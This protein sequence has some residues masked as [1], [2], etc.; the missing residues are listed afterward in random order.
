MVWK[1]GFSIYLFVVLPQQVSQVWQCACRG[2]VWTHAPS[3]LA[4]SPP[5]PPDSWSGTCLQFLYRGCLDHIDKFST[6][7]DCLQQ[8]SPQSVC[9]V[10]GVVCVCVNDPFPLRSSHPHLPYTRTH[11]VCIVMWTHTHYA[12]KTH[13]HMCTHIII[14]HI[15]APIHTYTHTRTQVL[16]VLIRAQV[17][18]AKIKQVASALVIQVEKC[19]LPWLWCWVVGL[20]WWWWRSI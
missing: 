9:T 4:L 19:D 3:F 20:T 7:R 1:W 6:S 5:H 8:C 13:M 11:T 18:R 16:E 14:Q 15:Y 2:H 10:C 12:H 17:Y